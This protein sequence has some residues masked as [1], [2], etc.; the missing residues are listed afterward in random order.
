MKEKLKNNTET[1]VS[2]I[3]AYLEKELCTLSDK[4]IKK[5]K[6]TNSLQENIEFGYIE[7]HLSTKKGS[8]TLLSIDMEEKCITLY[9]ALRS[10]LRTNFDL[11][12][13][14][15]NLCVIKL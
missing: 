14:E 3:S 7:I 6:I 12:F 1:I 4:I 2:M 13:S 5:Q 11:L 15:F 8:T 10:D 9:P